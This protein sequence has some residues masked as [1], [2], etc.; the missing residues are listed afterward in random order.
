M[1]NQAGLGG[2]PKRVAALLIPQCIALRQQNIEFYRI[3]QGYAS[4]TL[5]DLFS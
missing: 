4:P 5:I 1:M 2:N 3:L